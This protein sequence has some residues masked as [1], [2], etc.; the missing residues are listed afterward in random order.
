VLPGAIDG[1]VHFDDPGFTH[2]EDFASGTAAA[3]AGGVT[4]V[5]DMPCTSLPPVTDASALAHKLRAISPKAHVDFMLWGGVSANALERPDWRDRLAELAD[6][7]IAAIKVYLLSGMDS[8]RHLDAAQLR[9]VLAFARRLGV[10][11]GVHAE[12]ADLVLDATERL[13]RQGRDSPRAMPIRGRRTPRCGRSRRSSRPAG[14][15]VR[16]FTL[17]TSRPARH[18]TGSAPHAGRDCRCRPRP[19][20]TTSSSPSRTSSRWARCSRPRRW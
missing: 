12:D 6:A 1:H 13:R 18:S 4:C 5:V 7:G 20:R 15:R 9:E 14:S 17:S 8:F 2:R 19:A 10:P 16:A 3:A 11:V